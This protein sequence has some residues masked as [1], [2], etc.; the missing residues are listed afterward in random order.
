MQCRRDRRG[1]AKHIKHHHRA[2]AQQMLAA[3]LIRQQD[4]VYLH[5]RR[6]LYSPPVHKTVVIN[7]VGL[8]QSL[9]GEHTPRLRDFVSRGRIANIAPVLP[10]VTC[11]VQATYLTGA[12]PREHGIVGNGWYFRDEC[13]I[14][15]W[16]QSD[17]LV[18][19]PRIWDIARRSDADF[20]CANVCWWYAMY[21]GAE[22]TVTPRPM[23]LADGRK[24]PDIWTEPAELRFQLQERLGQF[25]LFKFWGPATSI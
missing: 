14:K 5:G 25:P 3:Q 24:I 15:V 16:R 8:T 11:S 1:R 23:Y 7:A 19:R 17:R 2:I 18:Q 9:L 13:E 4:N 6:I 21:S 22:F 12:M 10:A 20:T